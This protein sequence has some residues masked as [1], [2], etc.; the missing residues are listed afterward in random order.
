M[1]YSSISAFSFSFFSTGQYGRRV[2]PRVNKRR[3]GLQNQWGPLQFYEHFP[4]QFSLSRRKESGTDRF[5][6][7]LSW[8]NAN[9][10]LGVEVKTGV[11]PAWQYAQTWDRFVGFSVSRLL[12]Y[13]QLCT[14]APG[15]PGGPSLLPAPSL[16]S[17]ATEMLEDVQTKLWGY[18]CSWP[19]SRFAVSCKTIFPALLQ[20]WTKS[21]RAILSISA[22]LI[23]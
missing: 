11:L 13:S 20:M 10:V 6:K 23:I 9:S 12:L 3:V 19:L 15:G 16:P 7:C 2:K 1:Y 17:F 21:F 5:C 22:F 18:L 14:A 8:A 4:Y